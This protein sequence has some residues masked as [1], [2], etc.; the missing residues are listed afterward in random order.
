MNRFV[1]IFFFLLLGACNP[2]GKGPAPKPDPQP[3]PKVSLELLVGTNNRRPSDV[4]ATVFAYN[5]NTSKLGNLAGKTYEIIFSGPSGWNEGKDVVYRSKY[6]QNYDGITSDWRGYYR[7]DAMNGKYTMTLKVAGKSYSA[8]YTL[9]RA[10]FT[11]PAPRNLSITSSSKSSASITWNNAAGASSSEL[12]LWQGDYDDYLKG[13]N[14]ATTANSYTFD[15]LQLKDGIYSIEV[16]NFSLDFSQKPVK[17]T[18]PFGIS[19]DNIIFG[20]GNYT[21][22]L[23]KGNENLAITMPDAVLKAA[24]QESLGINNN[25]TCGDMAKLDRLRITDNKQVS[26][27]QGLEYANNLSNFSANRAGL[28]DISPLQ[29]LNLKYLNLNHNK[30]LSDFSAL[31]GHSNMQALFVGG[32]GFSN[33]D[34]ALVKKMPQLERLQLWANQGV[35]DLSALSGLNLTQELDIGGSEVRDLRPIHGL[36]KLRRLWIRYLELDNA[37]IAFLANFT[38][39]HDLNL[40]H[41]N[42][43]DLSVLVNNTSLGQGDTLDIKGNPLDLSAGSA[44][45]QAIAKLRARG[46]KVITQ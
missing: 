12:G 15:N 23:C 43:T 3:D 37:D 7:I 21:S 32:T 8:E 28:R 39:L 36:T 6:G 2:T 46:V 4:N 19:Y 20:V 40:Q 41:N 27:L 30:E 5:Y 45:Q 26:S 38:D 35:T 42:I 24:V 31:Q 14:N 34:M 13:Y 9:T 44:A 29:H 22:P 18:E 1:I 16:V 25:P 11:L 10:D 33:A 17:F